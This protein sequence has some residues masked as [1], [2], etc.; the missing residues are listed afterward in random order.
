[1][2]ATESVAPQRWR[3]GGG[4]TREL[5]AEPEG[6]GWSLRVSVAD[7][8]ADGP[9]S[10]FPG[11]ARWFT[12]I[13]GAGVELTID[14]AAHR[15]LAGDA[16]LPFDGA[17]STTCRLLAGATRDLNLML[18]GRSGSMSLARDAQTW[19]PDLACCGLYAAVAG[20]CVFGSG[21]Q[22]ID[23]PAQALLWF[24]EAPARIR[25]DAD[26][27]SASAAGWWLSASALEPR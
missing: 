21:D 13:E 23:M 4:V 1:M 25:F 26:T 27:T 16:P 10:V 5:L 12:V 11:V 18:R 7:I 15:L 8:E 9:F 2:I 17:A 19:S 22:H 3:N 20:R 6:A 24:D 14:G